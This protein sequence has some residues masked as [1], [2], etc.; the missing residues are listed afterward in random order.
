MPDFIETVKGDE[1]VLR[2]CKADMTS[3]ANFIWPVEGYVEC[4]DWKPTN[5]CGDGLHGALR[6]CGDGSLFNWDKDA[7]WQVVAIKE[8]I[9]LGGKVKF[10]SGFVV[11]T[12]TQ[13][14][15]TDYIASKYPNA[16]IIG[17]TATAGES[18]TATAGHR[19]TATAGE[20][21]TATAGHYGTATAGHY[22]TATA[23]FHGT[24]TAGSGGVVVIKYFDGYRK[25]I[26]VGYV[27]EDG[28]EPEVAYKIVKGKFVKANEKK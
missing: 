12:G 6:G 2:T 19:G 16:P 4:P 13:K 26:A 25:R 27:G 11:H 3:Y 23:G 10:P 21:G 5:K 9:D 14:S 22:G 7:V 15:A 28:I 8:W 17:G 1:L 18:G 20:S 24:A